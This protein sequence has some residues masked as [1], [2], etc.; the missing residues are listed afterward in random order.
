VPYVRFQHIVVSGKLRILRAVDLLLPGNEWEAHENVRSRQIF[1]TKVLSAV[2]RSREL[3]VQE[4]EVCLEVI[5]QE[6]GLYSACDATGD[7]LDEPGDVG[8]VF[9]LW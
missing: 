5:I 6:R 9:D 2:R 8:S 3:R 1:A 4:A 7:G